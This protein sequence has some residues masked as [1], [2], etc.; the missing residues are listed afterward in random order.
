MATPRSVVTVPSNAWQDLPPIWV[1]EAA[2]TRHGKA[3]GARAVEA[4]APRQ[5]GPYDRLAAVLATASS[6]GGRLVRHLDRVSA[7][8][9]RV[10]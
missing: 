10:S 7:S 8:T 4:G 1:D 3:G 6:H 9:R 2:A 5:R